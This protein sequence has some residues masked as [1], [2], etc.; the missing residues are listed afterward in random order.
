MKKNILTIVVVFAFSYSNA[1]DK[2]GQGNGFSKGDKFV[3]ELLALE[4]ET[5][6]TAGH[7]HQKWSI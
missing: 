3:E 2:D 4:Q 5:F 7:L 6:K 1:Q